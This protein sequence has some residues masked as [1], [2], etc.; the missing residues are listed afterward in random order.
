MAHAVEERLESPAFHL[1]ELLGEAERMIV[2]LD[3][4][5]VETFLT[6]LDEI[7]RLASELETSGLDLRPERTRQASLLS[8]L[9]RQPQ[10]VVSAAGG[11]RGLERLRAKHPPAEGLW[12]HLDVV[13][14][15]RRRV[16]ARRITIGALALLAAVALVYVLFTYI[17]PPDPDAV[18]SS[19]AV[20]T[21]Q[22]LA[23]EGKWEEAAGVIE[24]AQAKLKKEDIELL[25]WEAIVAEHLGETDKAAETLKKARSLVP[26]GQEVLYWTTLG[27]ARLMA[28]D[29]DGAQ[30]AGEEAVAANPE[31][32]QGYFLLAS[33]AEQ[34]GDIATAIDYFERTF[35]LAEETNP[36]LAVIARVRMGTLLQQAPTLFMNVT[37]T[38][39]QELNATPAP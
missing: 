4:D 26:P 1:R 24:E 27:N 9:Q 12:W 28:G 16:L 33:V 20:T 10:L 22:S 13:L 2:R 29:L 6:H 37:V 15:E 35:D 5:T 34:R 31:D 25:I 21:V 8:R 23:F 19:E 30:A 39:T 11:S 38:P 36:Q 7:E 18:V 3:R 14:A 17:F 32:P